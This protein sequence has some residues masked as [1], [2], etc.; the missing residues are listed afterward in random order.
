MCGFGL[1]AE[2]SSGN[3]NS[4]TSCIIFLAEIFLFPCE[5]FEPRWSGSDQPQRPQPKQPACQKSF[6]T[7]QHSS[8]TELAGQHPQTPDR[9]QR[10]N[11]PLCAMR[12]WQ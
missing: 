9:S 11:L 5:A 2:R 6:T 8:F 3:A 1:T 4:A 12:T 7:T 10:R